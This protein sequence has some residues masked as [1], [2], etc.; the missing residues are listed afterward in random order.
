MNFIA[1]SYNIVKIALVYVLCT[2]IE[3]LNTIFK[4]KNFFHKYW[5]FLALSI[6]STVAYFLIQPNP[7]AFQKSCSFFAHHIAPIYLDKQRLVMVE[8]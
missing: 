1:I 3:I 5:F 8:I 7:C 2:A 6:T 4:G